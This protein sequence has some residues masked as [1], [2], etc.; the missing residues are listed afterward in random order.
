MIFFPNNKTISYEIEKEE[1]KEENQ[2]EF[3]RW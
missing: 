3:E 1:E 2:K